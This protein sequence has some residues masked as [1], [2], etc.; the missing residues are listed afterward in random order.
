MFSGK[1]N[2]G[3]IDPESPAFIST[4][5][6]FVRR[7]KNAGRTLRE[8]P[9]YIVRNHWLCLNIYLNTVMYSITSM[10]FKLLPCILTYFHV[11]FLYTWIYFSF[12]P[13]KRKHNKSLKNQ[14]MEAKIRGQRKEFVILTGVL[15]HFYFE[16]DNNKNNNPQVLI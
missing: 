5:C 3:Q 16:V 6:M 2:G 11:C 15:G 7:K 14:D 1:N 4:M 9:A 10:Y 12:S 13:P 8:S